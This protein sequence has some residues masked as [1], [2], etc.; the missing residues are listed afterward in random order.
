[1]IYKNE[2]TRMWIILLGK[3]IK[4]KPS[5]VLNYQ[6]VFQNMCRM[7]EESG[8]LQLRAQTEART[9]MEERAAASRFPSTLSAHRADP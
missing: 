5:N 7:C 4:L 2:L 1:M 8:C 9:G 6:S 3:K